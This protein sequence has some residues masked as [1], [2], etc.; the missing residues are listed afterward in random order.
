MNLLR[1]SLRW[2]SLLGLAM[3]LAACTVT[4]VFDP[5]ITAT[6]TAQVTTS[7]TARL[8]NEVL[9][10]GATAYYRVE[11]PTARDLLYVEV[12]GANLRI[13]LY[14]ASGSTV[15]VSDSP[16]YFA[17]SLAT[18][19]MSGAVGATSDD[20]EALAIDVAYAC[21]GPCV[22][23]R[24]SAATYYVKV[25]NR[26]STSQP[27]DLFAYT[28]DHNDT[29]EPNDSSSSAVIVAGESDLIG[30]I[31]TVG[32]QDWFHYTGASARTLEFSASTASLDLALIVDGGPT[33][34]AGDTG[35][36]YP[37]E[38]F[39][40]VS[41]AQRA[42]PSGTSGYVIS[43][44]AVT[45][46][47]DGTVTA[48][49]DDTSP[50][51]LA[52]SVTVGPGATSVYRVD[53]PT[54]RELFYVEAVGTGPFE[55]RLTTTSGSTLAVS[56]NQDY[57]AGEVGDLRVVATDPAVGPAAIDVAYT[58]LGPCAAIEPVSFS[59][60]VEVQN[61]SATLSHSF[62][63][64]AYT[65]A[66]N[67]TFEA[68]DTFGAATG[69]AGAEVLIGAVELVGDVDWFRYDGATTRALAFDDSA[70]A[71]PLGLVLELYTST[72]AFI[73]TLVPGGV[74]V[75]QPGERF[76]VYSTT[77][78]AGPSGSAGYTVEVGAP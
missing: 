60:H 36:V 43:I 13:S 51:A 41:A 18:L 65:F 24:P 5:P 66:A 72:G 11:V 19:A 71:G 73:K 7:P 68:N 25:E 6:V 21:L 62:D 59:Y 44:G 16:T 45:S 35:V 56:R 27:F 31:E 75:V 64:Y 69:V 48:A 20:V 32:D 17:S 50:S 8:A 15:G 23:T 55:V 57:F 34:V 22:A 29:F 74:D 53:L 33:L 67:D 38:R 30:A 40:V 12:V 26:S 47:V 14:T 4:F 52:T 37:G 9:G 63:L 58:C 1:P 46:T 78:R 54:L 2:V 42:G 77:D 3:L 76:R 10:G 49:V 70:D 28:F 39:R 61:L